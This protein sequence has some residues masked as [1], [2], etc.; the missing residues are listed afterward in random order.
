MHYIEAEKTDIYVK[1]YTGDSDIHGEGLFANEEIPQG[2]KIGMW[3][4]SDREKA[5]RTL[6]SREWYET[7]PLGRMCNHSDTPNT[8][9]SLEDGNIYLVSKGISEG[10][11]ITVD[12]Q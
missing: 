4:T 8:E 10:E 2:D 6:V 5:H 11:E 1:Y 9:Y 12:Y 3:I 7:Y